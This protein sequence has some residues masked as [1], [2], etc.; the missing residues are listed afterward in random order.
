MKEIIFKDKT[1]GE[2]NKRSVCLQEVLVSGRRLYIGQ[3]KTIFR[4]K[5]IYYFENE[6]AAKNWADKM[7]SS[8]KGKYFSF[9]RVY[10][11]KKSEGFCRSRLV[12][13]LYLVCG[14]IV[15]RVLYLYLVR[16]DMVKN[17]E[18]GKKRK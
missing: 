18:V 6:A 9:L 16:I 15:F 10:N 12:D 1:M 13:R 7:A 11:S 8:E 5:G 4:V 2:K 3:I 14:N 17:L